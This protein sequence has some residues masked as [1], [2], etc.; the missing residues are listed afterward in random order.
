MAAIRA[1]KGWLFLGFYHRGQRYREYLNLRETRD[2]WREAKRI[3]RRIEAE[4]RSGTFEYVRAFPNGARANSL[5]TSQPTLGE[6]ARAWLEERAPRLRLQ[7]LYDY[8]CVLRTYIL[9]HPI[10]NGRAVARDASGATSTLGARERISIP[11]QSRNA[12]RASQFPPSKLAA[13]PQA[14]GT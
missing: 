8:Q 6:F 11:G 9:S 1:D 7:T 13:H 10:R 3:K 5:L 4:L 2:G 14:R 12:N